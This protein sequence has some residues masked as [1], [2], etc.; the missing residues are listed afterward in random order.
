MAPVMKIIQSW[1]A[2]ML[3]FFVV[4]GYWTSTFWPPV[5]R[6]YELHSLWVDDAKVGQPITM[7]VNRVIHRPF[8]GKFGV[9]VRQN[10][11]KGWMVVCNGAGGGDYRPDAV[12]PSPLTL[13]WWSNRECPV[14]SEPGE[15]AV[16]TT[17][18]MVSPLGF[19]RVL[20][21]ESNVFTVTN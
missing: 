21:H 9:V 12:L 2:T 13:G 8:F 14:A 17:I 19:R 11:P 6:W 3:L 5:E 7:H 10:T 20:K 1:S 15:Y 18:V 16:T 4:A